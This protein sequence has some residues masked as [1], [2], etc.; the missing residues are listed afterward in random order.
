[1]SNVVSPFFEKLIKTNSNNKINKF[2]FINK[3]I[4]IKHINYSVINFSVPD[5]DFEYNNS[6]KYLFLID[7]FS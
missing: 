2:S 6:K 5:D 1:M 7:L 3:P 4:P